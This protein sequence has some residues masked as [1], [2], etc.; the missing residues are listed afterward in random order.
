[1]SGMEFLT[2]VTSGQRSVHSRGPRFRL[3]EP[4]AFATKLAG[5]DPSARQGDVVR[6]AFARDIE[7]SSNSAFKP[8]RGKTNRCFSFVENDDIC[9]RGLH[10]QPVSRISRGIANC[11]AST[12][13][14]SRLAL[15]H[16]LGHTTVRHAGGSYLSESYERHTGRC[17]RHKNVNSRA[18]SWTP[19]PRNIT[20][21]RSMAPYATT[22]NSRSCPA[23]GR[24]RF[25][26]ETRS[27]GRA[28]H[29]R[30]KEKRTAPS[31][32]W[33]ASCASLT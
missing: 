12:C 16:E 2:S 20:C 21:R 8:L 3:E 26:R 9:R 15:G 19:V 17:F 4:Y 18:A 33:D 7:R 6:P 31:T 29:E 32:S 10:V 13:S 5:R 14:L 27:G 1:M 25:I 22:A 23:F 30:L 24:Y 11:W 28:L